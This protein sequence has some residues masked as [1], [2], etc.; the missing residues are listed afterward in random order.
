MSRIQGPT[1]GGDLTFTG[2][3]GQPSITMTN[4]G[5]VSSPIDDLTIVARRSALGVAPEAI[6]Y[7]AIVPSR[8]QSQGPSGNSPYDPRFHRVYYLWDFGDAG[9][10]FTAPEKVVAAHLNANRGFGQI[11]SHTSGPGPVNVSCMAIEPSSGLI[12]TGTFQGTV[13]DP[14]T[15]F[16]GDATIF[17]NP[18][19]N[20]ARAPQGARIVATGQEAYELQRTLQSANGALRFRIM[21]DREVQHTFQDGTGLIRPRNEAKNIYWCASPGSGIA[22]KIF[23]ANQGTG[24]FLEDE[25]GRNEPGKQTDIVIDGLNLDGYYNPQTGQNTGPGSSAEGQSFYNT[26]NAGHATHILFNNS[27]FYGFN[28]VYAGTQQHQDGID[29]VDLIFNNTQINGWPNFGVYE[30]YQGFTSYT[31]TRIRQD[32]LALS[33]GVKDGNG[34]NTHGPIR[35]ERSG[36]C[37]MQSSDLFSNNGWTEFPGGIG[38]HVGQ[39]CVR[40]NQIGD[41]RGKL[42]MQGCALE[43]SGRVIEIDLGGPS[44]RTINNVLI[45]KTSALAGPYTSDPIAVQHP[46]VTIRNCLI[47]QGGNRTL[48]GTTGVASLVSLQP[49]PPTGAAFTT[50]EYLDAPIEIY[51]N[52]FLNQVSDAETTGGNASVAA[53]SNAFA[54]PFANVIE[55][56][57]VFHQPNLGTPDEPFAPLGETPLWSQRTTGRRDLGHLSNDFTLTGDVANGATVDVPYTAWPGS[58]GQGDFTVS[59]AANAAHEAIVNGN[60]RSLTV[61][62]GATAATITNTSGVTWSSGDTVRWN[63]A[64]AGGADFRPEYAMAAG[65]VWA[66][67]PGTGSS[68]IDAADTGLRAWDDFYGNLL[69]SETAPSEVTRNAGAFD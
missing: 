21:F 33:G 54:T 49:F 36:K 16:S 45:D 40:W 61:T 1:L 35:I 52:T 30:A 10:V 14:N 11:A 13:L 42:N 58:L 44:E 63:L 27:Q 4:Y 20:G 5:V 39:P 65:L 51:N 48:Y 41:P 19:L 50:Q 59:P 43:S 29:A 56:N 66:A 28:Q 7:E 18:A 9:S 55:A 23:C 22:E 31:G 38:V 67:V 46:G 6:N 32:P 47:S 62:F 34:N 2:P 15:L 3:P 53:V 17:V 64:T 25:T 26:F 12:S 69:I 24:G 8:F 68:A 60:K 57:N 37:V